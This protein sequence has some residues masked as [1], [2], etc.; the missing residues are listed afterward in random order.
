MPRSHVFLYMCLF[1]QNI[2]FKSKKLLKLEIIKL[3]TSNIENQPDLMDVDIL[4]GVLFASLCFG[5]ISGAVIFSTI[6]LSF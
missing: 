1:F 6:P 3:E 4:I 5:V 2:Y